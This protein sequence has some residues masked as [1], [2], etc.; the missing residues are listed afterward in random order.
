MALA[1]LRRLYQLLMA[2]CWKGLVHAQ[3][4]TS[5]IL[6]A[7]VFLCKTWAQEIFKCLRKYKYM[8]LYVTKS[9]IFSTFKISSFF[10]CV[11]NAVTQEMSI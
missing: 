9:S 7:S 11:T 5:G 10:H 4:G 6:T 2:Q 3:L 1:V 8:D